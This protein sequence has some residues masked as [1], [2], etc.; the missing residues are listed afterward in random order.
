MCIRD[1]LEALR[2]GG[3]VQNGQVRLRCGAHVFQRVLEVGGIGMD[4]RSMVTKNCY[5]FLHTME[6]MGPAPE[7]NL[8]VLYLSLIHILGLLSHKA[9]LR[10]QDGVASPRQTWRLRSNESP[11]GAFKPQS[12]LA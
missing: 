3:G 1:S 11:S 10:K 9:V 7:P 4:G 12:G 6:N 5:R 8:T 2:Q